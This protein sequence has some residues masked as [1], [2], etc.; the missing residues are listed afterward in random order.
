MA[1]Q[2]RYKA[3]AKSI[4]Q[5][6]V[7]RRE[8]E[9]E[10]RKD[11]RDSCLNMKRFRG[12]ST[13]ILDRKHGENDVNQIDEF[14][15]EELISWVHGLHRASSR[16][17]AIVNLRHFATDESRVS[18][19]CQIE[20]SI[21][22]ITTALISGSSDVQIEAA[23]CLTNLS[24]GSHKHTKS[25]LKAAGAY[26]VT[27]LDSSDR[28][29]QDQCAWAIGN[30]AADC[31]SFRQVL[32][33][34]GAV[35]A[36]VP[37]LDSRLETVQYSALFAL[38][39]MTMDVNDEVIH[40]VLSSNVLSELF[41][42]PQMEKMGTGMLTEFTRLVMHLCSSRN[43]LLHESVF[44]LQLIAMSGN[45]L[46]HLSTDGNFSSNLEPITWIMR[47][48]ANYMESGPYSG[49]EYVASLLPAVLSSGHEYLTKESL[50]CLANLTANHPGILTKHDLV[51]LVIS[52][53]SHQSAEI[54]REAAIVLMNASCQVPN[55]ISDNPGIIYP[56]TE[57]LRSTDIHVLKLGIQFCDIAKARS[58]DLRVANPAVLEL[59]SS[60][61]EHPK[62]QIQRWTQEL[63]QTYQL[64]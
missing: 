42:L 3:G 17:S 38:A 56:M 30:I 7:G 45:T 53:L 23:W 8:E 43:P 19:L 51:P 47:A 64:S 27:Y 50:W 59:I 29:L 26:L 15:T 57:L 54:I 24:A 31:L 36:L 40:A 46:A 49:D 35:H 48:L 13:E 6:R 37:L 28:R 22:S 34:Q 16:H 60:L 9:L 33:A 14:S 62:P 25:V 61:Q 21:R 1:R 20:N 55:F 18:I 11:R 63:I 41:K 58:V 32:L 2:V 12:A 4:E 52:Y 10:K 44:M 39:N 5:L